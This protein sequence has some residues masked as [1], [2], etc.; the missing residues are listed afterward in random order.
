MSSTP[1]EPSK[2]NLSTEPL[3]LSVFDKFPEPVF[4]IAEGTPLYYNPSALVLFPDMKLNQPLPLPLASLLP[5]EE[6]G[7]VVLTAQLSQGN[8]QISLQV[9]PPGRLVLLRPQAPAQ[10]LSPKN[11]SMCL[12]QHQAGLYV[13]LTGLSPEEA[14]R[15]EREEMYLSVGLQGLHRLLHL[16]QQLDL[17]DKLSLPHAKTSPV[18]IL[19]LCDTV[20]REVG[21]LATASGYSFLYKS[22]N[23]RIHT[24]GFPDLLQQMLHL[25]LANAM[26]LCTAEDTFGLQLI[27]QKRQIQILVWNTGAQMPLAQL[28]PS[29]PRGLLAEDPVGLGLEL[30]QRIALHHGGSLLASPRKEGGLSVHVSLPI[31]PIKSLS[32]EQ[33]HSSFGASGGFSPL[34]VA[35]SEVLP[36][37]F[38]RSDFLE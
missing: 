34:L 22:E 9:H 21:S 15:T 2:G 17:L 6:E 28:F 36:Y 14:V 32:V 10:L 4:L 37:H 13:S 38:Y 16:A 5:L 26:R 35:F 24:L 1:S 30:A 18:D 25:L 19:A 7:D 31:R 33:P 27:K 23:S 20:A 11:I 29:H 12:R 3:F 8:F